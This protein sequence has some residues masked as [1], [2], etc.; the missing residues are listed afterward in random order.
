MTSDIFK[1]FKGSVETVQVK[2]QKRGTFEQSAPD[3][4]TTLDA[5]VKRRKST[6]ESTA[7]SEI[8]NTT[9]TIHFR[10]ED[11]EYIK[12]GNYVNIDGEWHTISDVKEGKDFDT[13]KVEFLYVSIANDI[14]PTPNTEP[15]WGEA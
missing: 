4:T 5:I 9:T 12:L 2:G 15:D 13:G 11:A 8:R 3:F 7:D 6:A 14:L 1:L 10:P